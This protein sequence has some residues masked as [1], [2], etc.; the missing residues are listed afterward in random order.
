MV[1]SVDVELLGMLVAD[2]LVAVLV[3]AEARGRMPHGREVHHTAY[4]GH[5]GRLAIDLYG[6]CPYLRFA[7]GAHVEEGT[8]GAAGQR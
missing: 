4:V 2:A 3:E 6:H 8:A 1:V 7:E 5:I